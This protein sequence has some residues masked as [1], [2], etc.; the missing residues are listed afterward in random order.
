MTLEPLPPIT[1]EEAAARMGCHIE[2]IRRWIRSGKIRAVMPGGYKL[3]YRIPPS[4]IDRLLR[5]QAAA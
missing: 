5:E 3:G 4:E 1:V 2:T